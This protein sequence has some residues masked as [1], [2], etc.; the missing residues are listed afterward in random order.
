MFIL[1]SGVN[2]NNCSVVE[3]VSS[4]LIYK[5]GHIGD[6]ICAIPSF[7]AIRRAYPEAHITLLT[8][9]GKKGKLGAKELLDGVWY[10]DELKVYYGEDISSLKKKRKFVQQLREIQYDLFIQLPDD[11]A[12][13]KILLRNVVFAK[14]LG[15]KY[16]FGFKIRTAK[17]FK[18]TQVDY[19]YRKTEVE[20]LLD[21][22]KENSVSCDKV[23]FS[24][25]IPSCEKDKVKKILRET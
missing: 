4:I 8:S 12:N 18:K 19:L 11:W 23:E 2:I 15:V 22:L 7:I 5:I 6:T 1:C 16:A 17:V 10:I 24:F 21:I 13:F 20:N 3:K 9:P 25:N 14:L